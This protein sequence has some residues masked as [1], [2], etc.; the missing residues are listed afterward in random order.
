MR[1]SV[2]VVEGAGSAVERGCPELESLTDRVGVPKWHPI[3]Y[4]VQG[5]GCHSGHSLIAATPL[6]LGWG[7]GEAEGLQEEGMDRW[8]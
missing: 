6:S 8:R 7:D 5:I 2:S 4:I 3:L 1:G